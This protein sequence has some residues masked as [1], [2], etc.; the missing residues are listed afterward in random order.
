MLV[1]AS[2]ATECAGGWKAASDGADAG[3]GLSSSERRSTVAPSTAM[4]NS[5]AP[6]ATRKRR[7][8]RLSLGSGDRRSQDSIY[9]VIAGSLL[10][11]D[12][13][14][15]NCLGLEDP[16][17]LSREPVASA[18]RRHNIALA[19]LAAA[20]GAAQ[21]IDRLA[22]IAFLDDPPTPRPPPATRLSPPPGQ[23]SAQDKAA[24]RTGWAAVLPPRHPTSAGA[25]AGPVGTAQIR[26]RPCRPW[27]CP[28][29]RPTFVKA[30]IVT[31][32]SS[33]LSTL[34]SSASRTVTKKETRNS[35]P[36]RHYGEKVSLFSICLYSGVPRSGSSSG[37]TLRTI[38]PESCS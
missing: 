2:T 33:C 30:L 16:L 28:I 20:K 25:G 17:D 13:C 31:G 8:G 32:S 1:N 24:C 34:L 9:C 10:E 15:Q 12:F 23:G 29:L 37:S 26:R 22:E 6:S 7:P 18:W 14:P 27:Q 5:A 36:W 38:K 21:Q 19:A 35:A 4:I 3:S 11:R